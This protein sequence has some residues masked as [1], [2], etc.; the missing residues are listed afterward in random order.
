[1]PGE[2]FGKDVMTIA[3]ALAGIS[4]WALVLSKSDAAV[5]II[6]ATGQT[7]GG[8]LGIVTLQSQYG[9]SFSGV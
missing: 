4:L 8:L 7:Y 5:N 1:M 3:L 6:K 2:G 9:N